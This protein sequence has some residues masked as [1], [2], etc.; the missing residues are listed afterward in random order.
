M[1]KSEFLE[2]AEQAARLGGAV[3]EQWTEKFTASEKSP[4]NLVTEADIESQ[5]AIHSCIC[6]RFP[7][8]QF[9][10]EEGLQTHETDSPYR[11]VI[12]PLDGTSNYVHHFPYYAVSIALECDGE[13]QVGVIYD[14]TRDELFSAERGQGAHLDG[15]PVKPS[16]AP[17]LSQALV[18][19]S[20]PVAADQTHP[21]VNEFLRVLPSAQHLQRTG[22]AA[23]NL[24]YVAC[25]RIDAYWSRTLNA[26]DMAAGVLLVSEAGGRVSHPNGRRIDINVPDVLASNGSAIHEQLR[27][28]LG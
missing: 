22:S 4:A 28:L 18:V 13:L 9:L 14:P 5:K 2:I 21:A 25:G 27:E 12:D 7:D 8:H 16:G 1:S 3:L 19:G 10:G 15:V 11:W 17:D 26:W 23:L 20:L 24:A 6:E